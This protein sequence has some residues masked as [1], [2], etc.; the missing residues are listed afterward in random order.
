ML[1]TINKFVMKDIPAGPAI[2]S[3]KNSECSTLPAFSLSPPSLVLL[4]KSSDSEMQG[5]LTT[6]NEGH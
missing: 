2:K 1:G 6:K 3:E 5:L 4:T